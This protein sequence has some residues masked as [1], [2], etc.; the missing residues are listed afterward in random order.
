MYQACHYFFA[1]TE[2]EGFHN[3]PAEAALCGS[4]VIC[5]NRPRNGCMDYCASGSA[6]VCDKLEEVAE[7]ITAR[8]WLFSPVPLRDML[9]FKIGSREKNMKR[10]VEVLS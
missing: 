3:P 9:K 8:L 5:M 7:I 1:P 4:E 10:L 6:W 2:L